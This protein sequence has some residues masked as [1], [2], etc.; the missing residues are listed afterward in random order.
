MSSDDEEEKKISYI[1]YNII[2]KNQVTDQETNKK[3]LVFNYFCDDLNGNDISFASIMLF[4]GKTGSGKTT[5]I[6]AFF[7][8]I[9]GIKLKDNCRY[10]LIKEKEKEKGQAESQTDGVH[11]YYIKDYNNKPLIIIDS[12][13]YGDTR[14]H[15]KDIE[16]N[17][18]FEYVFSHIIDHIN[19]ICFVVNSTQN[20]LDTNTKYIYSAVT[21][22]FSDD[23]SD[24]F[25]ILTTFGNPQSKKT[26]AFIESILKDKDADFLKKRIMIIKN[27]GIHLIV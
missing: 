9:K 21:A 10:I 6:N 15:H 4:A 19:I 12:Q 3:L 7:N 16:I 13:G 2:E 25:I 14:G 1:N 22:L 5:A 20:R 23:I 27:G 18:A 24:N 8:V 26:P 11:L 17:K